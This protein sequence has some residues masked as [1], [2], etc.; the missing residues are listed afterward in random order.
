MYVCVSFVSTCIMNTTDE[1]ATQI[2]KGD[3]SVLQTSNL[4]GKTECANGG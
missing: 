4:G 1:L 3:V 2:S